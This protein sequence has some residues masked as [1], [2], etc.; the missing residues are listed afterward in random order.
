MK[1]NSVERK[2]RRIKTS[3]SNKERMHLFILAEL[4]IKL[5]LQLIS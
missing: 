3:I 2:A 1:A 4:A 5:K